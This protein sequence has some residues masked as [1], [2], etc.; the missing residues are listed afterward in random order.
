MTSRK[1]PTHLVL[2]DAAVVKADAVE[3][4]AK[5]ARKAHEMR[6]EGQSWWAIAEELKITEQVASHLVSERIRSAADLYDEGAK[7]QMLTVELE[8]LDALQSAAWPQAMTGD[9]RSI[10]A[11]LKVIT[12]RT[13]L[14]GLDDASGKQVTNNTI[15]VPGSS[16]EYV[17]ALKAMTGGT[18]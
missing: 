5:L 9:T 10:D 16:V 14:L 1:T 13:R 12:V 2:A 11:V 3:K 15:V 4:Q 18:E 7:R 6:L 17:A 8:R